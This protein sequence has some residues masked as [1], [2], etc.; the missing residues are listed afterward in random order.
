M[1]K[2]SEV[3]YCEIDPDK[4]SVLKASEYYYYLNLIG[5]DPRIH[6]EYEVYE[7]GQMNLRNGV[8][9]DY[10]RKNN[11]NIHPKMNTCIF[12]VSSLRQ[13]AVV[14]AEI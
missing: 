5:V 3:L 11:L 8:I 7:L 14:I 1:G 10:I 2:I 4:C 9:G 6:P 12:G 13:R